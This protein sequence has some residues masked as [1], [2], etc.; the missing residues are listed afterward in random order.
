MPLRSRFRTW[1]L[2]VLLFTL[3][4]WQSGLLWHWSSPVPAAQKTPSAERSPLSS[5][6]LADLASGSTRVID[7]TWT[8]EESAPAWPAEA[9]P[10]F[11]L[12][13]Y[14]TLEKNGVLSQAISMPEHFGT[15]LDAPNHFAA[16]QIP[17]DQL[18]TAQL[19]G[20][21]VVIDMTMK[22]EADPDAELTETDLV[23]WEQQQGRIPDGAI[24][25]LKTGW[26]RH[27]KQPVR[28][29]NQDA[30]GQMHFPAYSAGAVRW[31][32]RE[33]KIRGL[34]IDTLSIDPG[35]SKEF[36]V[37]RLLNGSG[38][39]GLENVAALDQLPAR[40]F[41]VI[42]SPLKL[43]NGSGGPTRLYACLPKAD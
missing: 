16:R 3:G 33:R 2:A 8:L 32:I 20:P 29:L 1:T 25:F 21:G 37:H 26:G 15:H 40:E 18:T 34:G 9:A 7:M 38:L 22:S 11:Q 39:Y 30:R 19:I 24:L 27:W 41:V 36:P 5:V 12:N 13:A 31:L 43:K 28:Y 42:V 14:A 17:V 6:S 10:R 35:Q 23:Q 4:S